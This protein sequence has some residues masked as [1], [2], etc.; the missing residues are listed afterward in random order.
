MKTL[1]TCKLLILSSIAAFSWIS[2]AP[3]GAA[4]AAEPRPDLSE[5]VYLHETRG[6]AVRVQ[7]ASS[8]DSCRAATTTVRPVRS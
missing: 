6:V 1:W 2:A 4:S 5:Y 8:A 7:G 3:G